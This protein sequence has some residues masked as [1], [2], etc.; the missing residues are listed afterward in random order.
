M[1]PAILKPLD[2][3]ALL[4]TLKPAKTAEGRKVQER[5]LFRVEVAMWINEMKAV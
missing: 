5:V 3:V 4:L 2:H 1:N